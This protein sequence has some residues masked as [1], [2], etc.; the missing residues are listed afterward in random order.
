VPLCLL[1][2]TKMNSVSMDT[3]Q[4]ICRTFRCDVDNI[5]EVLDEKSEVKK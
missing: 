5:V 2:L 1:N 3:L 4:R